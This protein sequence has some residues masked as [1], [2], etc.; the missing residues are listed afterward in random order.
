MRENKNEKDCQVTWTRAL[1]MLGNG[2]L[3]ETS[4]KAEKCMKV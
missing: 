1:R 4:G 2:L 3:L